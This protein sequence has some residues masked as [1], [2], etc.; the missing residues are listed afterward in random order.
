MVFRGRQRDEDGLLRE[1]DFGL[2]VG[3]MR[4]GLLGRQG[5]TFFDGKHRWRDGLG[6]LGLRRLTRSEEQDEKVRREV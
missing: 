6:R 5:L 2:G 4:R 1:Q 3:H